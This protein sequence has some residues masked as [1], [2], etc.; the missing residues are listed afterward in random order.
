MRAQPASAHTQKHTH[1]YILAPRIG[2]GSIG[3]Y[4]HAHV[5]ARTHTYTHSS[6]R[7]HAHA[8]AHQV[9]LWD[10]ATL[11]RRLTLPQPPAARIWAVAASPHAAAAAGEPLAAPATVW[12]AVGNEVVVWG[13]L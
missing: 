2:P 9:V 10:A 8:H 5:R 4:A 3:Q 6:L 11:R 12:A 7:R 1:I 13:R